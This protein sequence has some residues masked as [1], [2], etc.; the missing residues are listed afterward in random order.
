MNYIE[1]TIHLHQFHIIH[2]YFIAK[3]KAVVD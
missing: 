2:Y 1:K 3:V